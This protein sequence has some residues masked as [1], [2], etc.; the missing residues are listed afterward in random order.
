LDTDRLFDLLFSESDE[1]TVEALAALRNGTDN[2]ELPA[3]LTDEDGVPADAAKSE[4]LYKLVKDA[5]MPQKI[6]LA[7]FG[8]QAVRNMLIRDTNRL[9]P[10][11]VLQN[12]RL[13]DAEINEFARNKDLDEAVLREIGNNTSWMKN[14][15]VKMSICFNPKVPVDVSMRWIKHLTTADLA[16][17]GKS[18]N[19]PQVIATQGRKLADQ[20]RADPNPD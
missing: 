4:N 10:Q 7:M 14:Y 15:T 18:K 6:K 19:V 11:F 13:T 1:Q 9:V 20:R 3:D 12:P 5:T 16:K 8:N 17:L 2:I